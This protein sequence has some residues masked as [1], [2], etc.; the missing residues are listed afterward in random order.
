MARVLEYQCRAEM[1][2]ARGDFKP[3]PRT[4]YQKGSAPVPPLPSAAANAR[5]GVRAGRVPRT[6]LTASRTS[7]VSQ[8]LTLAAQTGDSSRTTSRSRPAA[9]ACSWIRRRAA[10]LSAVGARGETGPLHQPGRGYDDP[11]A[12]CFAGGVPRSLYVPSPFYIIQTPTYV[13]ILLERMSWRIVPLDG[14]AHLPDTIRLWQ[15]DSL[16]RWEGDTLVVET[17]NLNGKSG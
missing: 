2:E 5:R 10:C 11:T 1:E 13:V 17:T 7:P 3:E 14:R 4:W 9:A 6:C 8:K 15:G 16:G 12:H